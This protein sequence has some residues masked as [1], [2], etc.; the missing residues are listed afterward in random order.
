LLLVVLV[1]RLSIQFQE[2]VTRGI[3]V[4]RAFTFSPEISPEDRGEKQRI[5]IFKNI[6]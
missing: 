6:F 3:S 4:W 5:T 2:L 1:Q